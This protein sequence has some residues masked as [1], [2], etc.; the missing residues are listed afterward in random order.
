MA[1][2]IGVFLDVKPCG[3][4]DRYESFRRIYYLHLQR[5]NVCPTS[6]WLHIPEDNN[7]LQDV[8]FFS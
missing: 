6:A 1:V 2:N 3:L 7:F 5:R 4:I 8:T